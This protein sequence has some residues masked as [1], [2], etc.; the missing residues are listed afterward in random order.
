[1]NTVARISILL[2]SLTT[3][4][5][6]LNAIGGEWAYSEKDAAQGECGDEYPSSNRRLFH[7]C[8]IGVTLYGDGRKWNELRWDRARSYSSCRAVCNGTGTEYEKICRKG[9]KIAR[10]IDD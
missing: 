8:V 3:L 1:M 9:C 6:S 5:Y 10:D 2:I 7:A 4:G